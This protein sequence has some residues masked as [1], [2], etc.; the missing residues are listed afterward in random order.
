MKTYYAN[1]EKLN[2]KDLEQLKTTTKTDAIMFFTSKNAQM[3]IETHI[4]ISNIAGKIEFCVAETEI[5]KAFEIGK[6]YGMHLSGEHI[7]LSGINVPAS[8]K[9]HMELSDEKP[10]RKRRTTKE[11]QAAQKDE[12]KLPSIKK[13]ENKDVVKKELISK[14]SKQ[15]VQKKRTV[16]TVQNVQTV[17]KGDINKTS[18]I[19]KTKDE[20]DK[21]KKEESPWMDGGSRKFFMQMCKLDSNMPQYEEYIDGCAKLMYETENVNC[22]LK[23]IKKKYGKDVSDL[24][25][26][27]INL[28]AS[29]IKNGYDKKMDDIVIP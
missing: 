15:P 29:A 12:E 22:A 18:K 19:V 23:E 3:S 2:N 9:K 25:A 7:F 24:L 21:P 6:M 10:K 14:D 5:D 1:L 17:Q 27:N 4:A 20:K 16:Q 13:E 8:V 26:K 11:K 28:L